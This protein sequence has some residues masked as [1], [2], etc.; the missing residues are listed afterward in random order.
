MGGL[1]FRFAKLRHPR[2][3]LGRLGDF[4]H[5]LLPASEA[6]VS[7][8]NPSDLFFV[9]RI[10]RLF[11]F[12]AY[13]PGFCHRSLSDRSFQF[14]PIDPDSGWSAVTVLLLVAVEFLSEKFSRLW[15]AFLDADF[16]RGVCTDFDIDLNDLWVLN[17][18]GYRLRAEQFGEAG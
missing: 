7:I 5:S 2:L 12:D 6:G 3:V 10:D 16:A 17:G 4:I 8:F 1:N 15:L 11:G 18:A 13:D 9:R 14:D